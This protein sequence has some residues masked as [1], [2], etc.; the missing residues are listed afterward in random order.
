M[1]AEF[2]SG[3]LRGSEVPQPPQPTASQVQLWQRG[4]VRQLPPQVTRKQNKIHQFLQKNKKNK[5]PTN[6]Q[7][8]VSTEP[9]CHL[10]ISEERE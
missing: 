8:Q 5:K 7:K 1:T 2:F 4:F 6:L 9:S 10:E 3:K